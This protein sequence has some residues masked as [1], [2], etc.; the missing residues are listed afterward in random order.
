M[1]AGVSKFYNPQ[2]V[3][4]IVIVL[5]VIYLS[6][7]YPWM[8]CWGISDTETTMSLPGD[9]VKPSWVITSTRGITIHA[10]ASEVWKWVVQLGQERAGF[11]S[12]DWLEN[13]VLSNIHN[14]DEI[15]LEWQ[16]H[17]EGDHVLGAGGVI[18]KQ[19]QYWTVPLYED[20]KVIY[21]WGAIVVQPVDANTSRL[22]TRSYNPP[23]TWIASTISAFSYDWM[24]FVMER[25]MLLGVKA[26]AEGTLGSDRILRT[27]SAFGWILATAS[28]M[29]Y[30]FMRRSGWWWGLIP[31]AYAI[32]IFI[33][34]SDI[35]STM[36]GFL[37]WGVITT[38]FL[39]FGRSWWN[40]LAL[41]T[42][43]VV[44]TFV[45]APQPHFAFGIIFLLA[46]LGI[47]SA[48]FGNMKIVR[49]S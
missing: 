43:F 14:A 17:Q 32:L 23:A 40:G 28:M 18:Y 46:T 42:A 15:R 27:I 24:H 45:L 36:A 38:G 9:D 5:I 19:N 44:L 3:T 29:G 2:V 13:L 6:I 34:T 35:W 39:A 22:Y 49:Q 4:S 16:N 48:K 33:F 47:A 12:N 11:Y 41:A 8:N 30:L 25:G 37:W 10:P 26:R 21:L 1:K 31:L 20:G 7:I